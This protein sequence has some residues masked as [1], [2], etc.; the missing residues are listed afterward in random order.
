MPLLDLVREIVREIVTVEFVK[1]HHD[2]TFIVHDDDPN[3]VH[4]ARRLNN[5][6]RLQED[7]P[8]ATL[9][10]IIE[11]KFKIV[12]SKNSKKE[13]TYTYADLIYDIKKGYVQII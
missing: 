8:N 2:L 1:T 4:Y 10:D 6:R 11:A 7:N 3:N 13:E 5:I 12:R 9:R